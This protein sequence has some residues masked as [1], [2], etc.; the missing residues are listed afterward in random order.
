MT[1]NRQGRKNFI[2]LI[3]NIAAA[4]FLIAS[5]AVFAVLCN[6]P[7]LLVFLG[8]FAAL[9]AVTYSALTY[10][11]VKNVYDF[12][13]EDDAIIFIKCFK[14]VKIPASDCVKIK[15]T[16]HTVRFYRASSAESFTVYK[17]LSN[18][19]DYYRINTYNFKNAKFVN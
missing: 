19:M 6:F 8:V 1:K 2:L 13:I 11:V 14:N 16:L 3:I 9:M 10:M 18:H 17:F 7:D 4:V 12:K 5:G 15:N